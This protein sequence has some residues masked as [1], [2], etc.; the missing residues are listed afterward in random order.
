MC[1]LSIVINENR[2][3]QWLLVVKAKPHHTLK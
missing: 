2:V 1:K 3:I